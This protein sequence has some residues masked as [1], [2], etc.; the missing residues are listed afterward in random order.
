M[1]IVHGNEKILDSVRD[2]PE[3]LAGFHAHQYAI[4]TQQELI[5]YIMKRDEK[6]LSCMET[7]MGPSLDGRHELA[8][9]FYAAEVCQRSDGRDFGIFYPRFEHYLT[10][11]R[12]DPRYSQANIDARVQEKAREQSSNNNAF[13]L[14]LSPQQQHLPPPSHGLGK[15]MIARLA[16]TGR[17]WQ[18][19]VK[20]VPWAQMATK[21]E[22]PFRTE[23]KALLLEAHE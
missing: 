9:L 12:E 7:E 20:R 10:Y 22:T 1:N 23:P 18:K 13:Q 5:Y 17:H 3:E 2:D 8:F 4:H 6:F 14:S 15:M 19:G 16:A 21:I 11:W